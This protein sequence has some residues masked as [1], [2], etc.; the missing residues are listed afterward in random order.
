PD[1]GGDEARPHRDREAVDRD[2][3]PVPLRERVSLDR[4][5]HGRHGR[6]AGRSS[7][8]ARVVSRPSPASGSR[9]AASPCRV[10]RKIAGARDAVRPVE[11]DNARMELA[12]ERQRVIGAARRLFAGRDGRI[13]LT[14]VLAVTATLEA[15]LYTQQRS[16]L[17]LAI[18]VNVLAV[19]PLL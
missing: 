4:R 17:V 1:E 18:L 16:D 15:S 8:R 10:R 19:L 14:L 12:G 7:R 3:P 5:V 6:S 2:R 13:A 11:G 9:P